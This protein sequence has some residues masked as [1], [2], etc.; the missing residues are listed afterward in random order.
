MDTEAL[1]ALAKAADARPELAGLAGFACAFSRFV[2]FPVA[3]H[4]RLR[5]RRL[6]KGLHTAFVG[7][8]L[9]LIAGAFCVGSGEPF[10]PAAAAAFVGGFSAMAWHGATKPRD[11]G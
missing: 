3:Q 4:G 7:G 5:G 6:P 1:A 8:V 10:F 9:T 11:N 2:L